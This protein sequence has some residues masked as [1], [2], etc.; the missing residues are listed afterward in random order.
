VGKMTFTG[1]ALSLL[2]VAGS[3][4]QRSPRPKGERLDKS[5]TTTNSDAD[6]EVVGT[7]DFGIRNPSHLSD[8]DAIRLMSGSS[9]SSGAS[10]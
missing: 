9:A 1:L 4:Q 2:I 6:S 3:P 8:E 5:E 7:L 10:S